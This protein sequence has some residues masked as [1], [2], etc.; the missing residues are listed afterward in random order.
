MPESEISTDE[1]R[2]YDVL[3]VKFKGREQIFLVSRV[4]KGGSVVGWRLQDRGTPI[5]A[6][7]PASLKRDDPRILGRSA[8][9]DDEVAQL[10]LPPGVLW[11]GWKDSRS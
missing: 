2:P 8:A 10:G 3:A 11:V 5:A 9:T 1:L 7:L 6:W 4:K